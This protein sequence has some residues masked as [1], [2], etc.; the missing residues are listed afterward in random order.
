MA[1]FVRGPPSFLDRF[2]SFGKGQ[3]WLEATKRTKARI[4]LDHAF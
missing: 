4:P 1:R 2:S 3:N